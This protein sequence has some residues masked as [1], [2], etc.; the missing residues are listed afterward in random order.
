MIKKIL[1]YLKKHKII[2]EKEIKREFNLS[3]E[4]WELILI[5][6]R[7]LGYIKEKSSTPSCKSCPFFRSCSQGC[8]KFETL[9]LEPQK[10]DRDGLL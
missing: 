8:L 9:S 6:L 1:E 7:D 4:E 2:N 3:D 5:Q 10:K